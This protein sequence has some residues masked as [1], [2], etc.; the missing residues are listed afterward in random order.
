MQALNWNDLRHVLAV[1][2]GGSL[3]AAAKQLGVDQTTVTRRLAAAEA[4][5]G[6]RLFE[7][8]EGGALEPTAAGAAAVARAE[9]VEQEI[10]SLAAIAGSNAA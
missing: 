1:A 7:R 9:R 4:A 2:R 10:E 8:G 6:A 5:L 3:A